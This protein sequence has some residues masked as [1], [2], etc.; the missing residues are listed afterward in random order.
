MGVLV[1]GWERKRWRVCRCVSNMDFMV[2]ILSAILLADTI[3][4]SG[5]R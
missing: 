5:G 4:C 2:I 1:D 3:G